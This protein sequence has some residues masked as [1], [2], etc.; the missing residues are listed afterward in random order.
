MATKSL[1]G[2]INIVVLE[3]KLLARL[4]HDG[5]Y[6]AVV[7]LDDPGEEMVSCL[8]VESSCEHGPE[9]AVCRIVLCCCHL[10]LCPVCRGEWEKGVCVRERRYVYT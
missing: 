10:H 8:V 3:A 5:C 1:P 9:P 6:T 2:R 7:G 4:L